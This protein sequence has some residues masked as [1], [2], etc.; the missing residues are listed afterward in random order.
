MNLALRRRLPK[1]QF[2]PGG[3]GLKVPNS[4]PPNLQSLS[5]KRKRKNWRRR[6]NRRGKRQK[7]INCD[8]A[9]VADFPRWWINVKVHGR[10]TRSLLDSGAARTIMGPKA[11]DLAREKGVKLRDYIG[12]GVRVA[13]GNFVPIFNVATFDFTLGKSTKCLEV[14]IMPN[15]STECIP[16][17]DFMCL[18]N[19]SYT[20]ETA[21][22][23]LKVFRRMN[24]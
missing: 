9:T 13:N 6:L 11:V 18:F 5:S 10:V 19:V 12:S 23:L 20:L 15:L 24:Q 16:G 4:S 2:K 3:G 7:V 22:S 21:K 14:L 1:V 8:Q 17:A